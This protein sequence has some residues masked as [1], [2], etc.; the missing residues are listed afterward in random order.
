MRDPTHPMRAC[1]RSP[2]TRRDLVGS[3]I[4]FMQ[5]GSALI[6]ARVHKLEPSNP[7]LRASLTDIDVGDLLVTDDVM[8]NPYDVLPSY[9]PPFT[10]DVSAHNVA[11]VPEPSSAT[12]LLAALGVLA[13]AS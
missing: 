7:I 9:W 13:A 6:R 3:D 2:V 1:A 10:A 11:A 5:T 8:D 12:L 4:Q